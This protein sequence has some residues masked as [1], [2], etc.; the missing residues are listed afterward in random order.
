MLHKQNLHT[1]QYEVCMC[2]S[3]YGSRLK[4]NSEH[5]LAKPEINELMNQKVMH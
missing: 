3:V 1:W 4:N 2:V 5:L